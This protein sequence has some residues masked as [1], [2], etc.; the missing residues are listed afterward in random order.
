MKQLLAL[1]LAVACAAAGAADG[2]AKQRIESQ[3][4]A[5]KAQCGKLGSRKDRKACDKRAQGQRDVALADLKSD[6]KHGDWLKADRARQEAIAGSSDAQY[7]IEKDRCRQLSGDAK[8]HC[9]A[10]AKKKFGKG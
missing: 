5:A 4:K 8:D 6:P 10:D 2:G 3:Y 9:I 1:A 7:S